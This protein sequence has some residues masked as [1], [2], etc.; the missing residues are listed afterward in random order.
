MVAEHSQSA[1]SGSARGLSAK[2]ATLC[3]RALWVRAVAADSDGTGVVLGGVRT[4]LGGKAACFGMG[5]TVVLGRRVAEG[6]GPV[7][8]VR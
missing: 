1:H 8:H 3:V 4:L 6:A 5:P 7:G 2:P